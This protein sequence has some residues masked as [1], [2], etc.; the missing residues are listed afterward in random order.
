[1]GS[2]GST[3]TPNTERLLSTF[4]RSESGVVVVVL[5]QISL[6]LLRALLLLLSNGLLVHHVILFAFELALLAV[7]VHSG[8]SASTR[9]A[10]LIV[11]TIPV[12]AA[13]TATA[14]ATPAWPLVSL[15]FGLFLLG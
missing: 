12:A 15:F 4:E 3:F 8:A 11:V 6:D 2:V 1:V 9:P 7:G 10:V 13:S 5:L 14:S